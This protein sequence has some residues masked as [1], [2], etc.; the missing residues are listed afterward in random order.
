MLAGWWRAQVQEMR[1]D[2]GRLYRPRISGGPEEGHQEVRRFASL[3]LRILTFASKRDGLEKAVY[4]IE[5]AIKRSKTGDHLSEGD[6][7]AQHLRTLLNEA[8]GLLPR[9]SVNGAESS[10]SHQKS[11]GQDQGL[12]HQQHQFGQPLPGT[13]ISVI[14]SSDD[15]FE[16]D[17]A[18]NPLQLLARASDLSGPPNQTSYTTNRSS[19]SQTRSP[20]VG[21]DPELRAFFGPFRPSL[22]VGSDIDPIDM[23]LVTEDEANTLFQ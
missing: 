9:Q 11:P 19:F 15:N 4:Q 22:D 1:S 3:Y 7:D 21:S 18:E 17:D 14:Q 23:G 2:T 12:L 20:N 5:Q 6:R 16:V 10:F 13:D 8:Q